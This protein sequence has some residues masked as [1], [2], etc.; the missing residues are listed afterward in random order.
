[1]KT[2]IFGGQIS[3][4]TITDPSR[5][6]MTI[7]LKS[8]KPAVYL[9]KHNVKE[10]YLLVWQQFGFLKNLNSGK[11]INENLVNRILVNLTGGKCTQY[12]ECYKPIENYKMF[13]G[14]KVFVFGI[15]YNSNFDFW[16]F[17]VHILQNNCH[18]ISD[19]G[20]WERNNNLQP[21]KDIFQIYGITV[22]NGR[23]PAPSLAKEN[24]CRDK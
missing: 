1:M 11:N 6:K 10:S 13:S 2:E 22:D 3:S 8:Q 5:A 21:I 19:G 16:K 20:F 9:G 24:I 12:T 23:G 14:K 7:P 15:S 18:V 17:Q 4:F